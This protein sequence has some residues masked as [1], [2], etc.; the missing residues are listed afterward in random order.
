MSFMAFFDGAATTWRADPAALTSAIRD[1]W[2]DLEVDSRHRSEVA[3]Y[4]W[5]FRADDGPVDVFFAED[6]TGLYVD[7]ALPDAA[8]VACLLRRFVPEDV[9]L[10]FCDQ[11]YSFDVWISSGS[12]AADL[13]RAVD[14]QT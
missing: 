7:A 12:T 8:E 13:V 14:A 4:S 3:A 9:A 5:T 1:R 10:V 2:D 11:G 6:G